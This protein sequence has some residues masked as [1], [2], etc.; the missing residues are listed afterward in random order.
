MTYVNKIFM[1]EN[2]ADFL[3]IMMRC[4]EQAMYEDLDRSADITNVLQCLE[5][6]ASGN[7]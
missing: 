4:W 6:P 1:D 3:S 7:I 2:P 5:L